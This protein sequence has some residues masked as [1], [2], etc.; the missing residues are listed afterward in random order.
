ME[1]EQALGV[2]KA[3]INKIPLNIPLCVSTLNIM[4]FTFTPSWWTHEC[5]RVFWLFPMLATFLD[6]N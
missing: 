2:L 1:T 6:E 3:F 4:F 5:L